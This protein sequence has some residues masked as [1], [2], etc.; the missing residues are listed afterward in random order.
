VSAR[1]RAGLISR[2]RQIR[3]ASPSEPVI[4]DG[5][6]LE[7]PGRIQALEARV[8][9]LEEL[10]KG[11]QDSVYR[12]AQREGK[13]ITDLEARIDPTALAASLSKNAR[14]RGL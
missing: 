8:K 4:A 10:I 9:Y 11:L 3:T 5:Q 13:R 14:E 2:M 7:G 12:E 1:G 6:I